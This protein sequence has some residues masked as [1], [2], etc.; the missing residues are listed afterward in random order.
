MG[1]DKIL[2]GK[3]KQSILDDILTSNNINAPFLFN[4]SSSL[5]F[6]DLAIL[7]ST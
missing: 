3:S 6:S 5:H 4:Y 1:I 2:K 7:I